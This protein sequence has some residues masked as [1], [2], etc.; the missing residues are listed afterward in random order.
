MVS[1][2]GWALANTCAIHGRSNV[3]PLQNV[4]NWVYTKCESWVEGNR[5]EAC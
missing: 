2:K 5:S 4:I 3:G 1:R